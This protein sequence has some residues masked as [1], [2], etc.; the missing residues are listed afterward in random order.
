MDA[1]AFSTLQ[2]V[3][4][5]YAMLYYVFIA[6]SHVCT[7]HGI[8]RPCNGDMYTELGLM[9]YL[10]QQ[11]HSIRVLPQRLDEV[12]LCVCMYEGANGEGRRE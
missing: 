2:Y 1:S 4:S 9:L 5:C 12:T 6:C 8:A 7:F 10:V 11:H 3:M